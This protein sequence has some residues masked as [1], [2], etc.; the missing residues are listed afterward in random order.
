[1]TITTEQAEALIALAAAL[2]SCH[3][4]NINIVARDDR[5]VSLMIHGQHRV[6]THTMDHKAVRGLQ[7]A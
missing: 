2:E 1:M 4:L 5:Q 7:H 6:V 3:K